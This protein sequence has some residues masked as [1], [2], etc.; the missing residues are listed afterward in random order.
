M[1]PPPETRETVIFTPEVIIY[2]ALNIA[3]FMFLRAPFATIFGRLSDKIGRKKLV[4]SGLLIYVMV[5]VAL[6]LARNPVEVVGIRAVQGISSAMVWPVAQALLM[7]TVSIDIRTRA[8]TMFVMALNLANLAGPGLGGAI[9]NFFY[10]ANPDALAIDILRPTVLSPVPAF[11]L[12]FILS[13][14][15]REDGF[16]LRS[17]DEAEY[18]EEDSIW[19]IDFELIK[20]SI[21]T[22]YATGIING[23]GIGL[24]ASI[25]I[26][27]IS[28]FVIKEPIGIGALM[29]LTG[30]VGLIVA[31]PMARYADISLGKKR[32]AIF[33][34]LLRALAFFILPFSTSIPFIALVLSLN[35][36]SFNVGM[37]SLRALQA[38]LTKKSFR[39]KVFGQQQT[40]F[41]AGMAIGAVIGAFL[42]ILYA[43]KTVFSVPGTILVFY[44]SAILFVISILLIE[45]YVVEPS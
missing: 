42:Y 37:P 9:Y 34:M 11:I 19:H 7:E 3:A 31:Y 18:E 8:M 30:L 13:F 24:V 41:N 6:G 5:G 20:R 1:I 2:M 35:S 26:I 36:I 10:H 38:D 40:F 39:G 33:A 29:F 43:H 12:A 21:Y 14:M 17:F 23:F 22:I 44:P 45:K 27:Y 32:M 4:V 15:L 16:K 25:V 28:E